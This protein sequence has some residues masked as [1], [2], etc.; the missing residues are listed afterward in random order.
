[1]KY[2]F[3]A[4]RRHEFP[5]ALMC[6]LLGVSR[7][8]FYAAR[9]RQP[10]ARTLADQRLRMQICAVHRRSRPTY[11][12]PRVHAELREQGVRCGRKRIERLMRSEGLV[13]KPR[14][15]QRRT[16]NSNHPHPVAP[17]V[18]ARRFA[19][20]AIQQPARVWASDI[21]YVPTRAGWLYL[22]VVLELAS[23][24]VVGWA[25]QPT[26]DQSRTH[27]ALHMALLRRRP[28]PG[29]LHHSDRGVQ[30]AATNY[31]RLL[32]AH[33]MT[34]S[35]SRTGDC[36]DNAVVESFFATLEWELFERADWHTRVEAKAA[37]FEYIEVWY[38]R[39]RRHST[40]G[41]L[42]PVDYEHLLASRAEAVLP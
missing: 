19:V 34:P 42:S 25:M 8:G 30:Y 13:A 21:T 9:K 12:S 36:Y 11:G 39:Q 33:G 20:T 40:L 24:V 5:L 26:L 16:T 31:Q 41:Y 2:A 32:A 6:R 1:V 10:S 29:V 4:T 28:K 15:R 38:N 35:M 14:R 23:R 3:I 17:N 27:A 37:I 18:L 22:A 7:S